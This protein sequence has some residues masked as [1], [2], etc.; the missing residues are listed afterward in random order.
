MHLLKDHHLCD[1]TPL[2]SA[3]ATCW[4]FMYCM[5]KLT[6]TMGNV[7]ILYLSNV[8]P[9]P[10]EGLSLS[11]SHHFKQIEMNVFSCLKKKEMMSL[12]CIP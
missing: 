11:L 8:Y 6:K 10:E 7:T 3:G 9:M 5:L 4:M 2:N 1:Y 12:A